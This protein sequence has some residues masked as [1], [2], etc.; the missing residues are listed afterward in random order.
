MIFRDDLTN[1]IEV[2]LIDYGVAQSLH[3]I[4]GGDQYFKC[5]HHFG[6]KGYIAPELIGRNLFNDKADVFS[7]GVILFN[8]VS[9]C[10]LFPDGCDYH[11]MD[12]QE[13]DAYLKRQFK[14]LYDRNMDYVIDLLDCCLA[15]DVEQRPS[16]EQL[17]RR[18]FIDFI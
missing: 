9:G 13:Y 16:V 2:E 3:G 18:F 12:D 17:I 11:Q 8:M 15:L 5:S 6:T 1:D 4:D 7:A 14:C 10:T